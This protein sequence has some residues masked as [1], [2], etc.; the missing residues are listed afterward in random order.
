[1]HDGLW[2]EP[3][4]NIVVARIRGDC[5][6]QILIECERRVLTLAEDTRQINVLYDVLEMHP[7]SV[8]LVLFQ[9]KLESEAKEKLNAVSLRK[10]ILVP[11]S[12]IAFLARLAFGQYGEGQYRVFYN[13][14]SQAILWL[15]K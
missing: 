4:G 13:D 8:D 11:N 10:A 6:E 12:R 5:N 3:L 2:V 1:M 14:I 7:P 15:E 9:Q